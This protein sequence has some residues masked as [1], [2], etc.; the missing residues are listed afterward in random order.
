MDSYQPTNRSQAKR[1][2]DRTSCDHE[3]VH[4]LFDALPLC[5]VGYAI[6]GQPY[7][8]PTLQWR[9]GDRLYWHGS[10]ASRMIRSI[11]G[12][13]V[14]VTVSEL[15]GYVMARSPFHHSVNYRSAMAFGTASLIDD[16]RAKDQALEHMFDH[17]FPGR[18]DDVRAN[19]DKELKAT[20]VISMRIEEASAKVRSGG[21]VDDEDD[22]D[23]VPCWAGVL[24]VE[25]GYGD[26]VDDGR[27]KPGVGFPDYLKKFLP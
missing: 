22:Y 10:S 19:T 5:H 26:P 2:H 13:P 23:A 15:N 11:A 3:T 27:L 7:V 24:P 17:L 20:S 12:R 18:W 14:C 4:N 9:V 6:D 21:P 25:R 16:P 1:A 8:T